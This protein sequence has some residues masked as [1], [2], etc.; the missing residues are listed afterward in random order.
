M[1]KLYQDELME[2]FK[3]PK[4]KK[5][6]ENADFSSDQHNPSCG[7]SISIQ[8]MIKKDPATEDLIIMQLAF[9][10]SGCVISQATASML[11]QFCKNKTVKD[12]LKLNKNDILNLIKIELGPTRLRCALLAL[13]ALQDA[14]QKYVK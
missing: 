5:K 6:I 9:E 2:H 4:N 11:T 1:N 14:L 8:G 10:G 13:Q 7:D 12:I 3:Y